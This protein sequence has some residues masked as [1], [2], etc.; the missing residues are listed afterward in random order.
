MP[1]VVH[2]A[3]AVQRCSAYLYQLSRAAQGERS[4]IR[5]LDRLRIYSKG[6]SETMHRDIYL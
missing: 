5:P 6:N 1:F 3:R 4:S 2:S